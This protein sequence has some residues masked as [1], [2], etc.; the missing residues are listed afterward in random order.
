VTHVLAR[1]YLPATQVERGWMAT[2]AVSLLDVASRKLTATIL[3]DNIGRGAANPWACGFAAGGSRLLV[4]HAGT[5]ELSVIDFAALRA[6][7]ARAPAGASA[8]DLSFLTGIRRRVALS[9]NG[10]RAM[11]VFGNRVFVAGYF[12]DSVEAV[13]VDAPQQPAAVIARFSPAAASIERRGEMLF[14]DGSICFQGWQSCATCHS[15]DARVDGLNWDLMNDGLGNPKNARSLLL[16]HRTPP[17]MSLGVR[18]TTEVAVRS[19]LRFILF[20]GMPEQEAPAID[21]YLKA[22]KPVASPAL[23]RGK[24]SA[25]AVRGRRLFFSRRT[26]CAGCHPAG[27]F[28]DLKSYDVGTRGAADRV[29]EFDTPTLVELWRTAPYLHDGSAATVREVLTIFNRG[30]RHGRTSHLTEAELDDL[31]AYL[32]SL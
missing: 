1:Y 15:F 32:M 26:G 11:A 14:N 31:A 19:G 2:N 23:V 5:H 3:L 21:A 30:D 7:L 27:L 20:A 29:A 4:T 8:G 24:L 16:S 22:L 18:E 28:T 25:A 13:D 17:A 6:K 12:S 10:P 9:G